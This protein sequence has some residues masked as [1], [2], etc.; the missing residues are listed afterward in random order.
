M[1]NLLL[2]DRNDSP[3]SVDAL[4]RIFRSVAGF[5]EV[6]YNTPTGTPIE[7]DFTQ[8]ADFTTVRLDSE[9]ETISISGTSE[10]A[11]LAAWLL[12]SHLRSPLRIVD[13]DYSFDLVVSD[14]NSFEALHAAIDRAREN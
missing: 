9:R 8:D 2:F 14:F 4:D 10:A 6:R 5:G 3:I 7:A 11:L 1:H 12:Q 13:T